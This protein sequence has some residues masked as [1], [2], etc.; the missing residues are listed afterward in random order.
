MKLI[1]DVNK[2]PYPSVNTEKTDIAHVDY[3]LI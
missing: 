3:I 1:H 2:V